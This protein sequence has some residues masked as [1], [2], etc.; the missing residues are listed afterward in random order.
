MSKLQVGTQN[1]WEQSL[2]NFIAHFQRVKN[3]DVHYCLKGCIQE[4]NLGWE[5]TKGAE[6][7]EHPEIGYLYNVA[8]TIPQLIV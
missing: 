1:A 2:Q 4:C 5:E 7:C 3:Y 8:L 6:A